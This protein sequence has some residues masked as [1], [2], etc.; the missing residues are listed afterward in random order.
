M[1]ITS[2]FSEAANREY[3]LVHHNGVFVGTIFQCLTNMK[4]HWSTRRDPLE[5]G[6]DYD[7]Y[8]HDT[9]ESAHKWLIY[10]VERRKEAMAP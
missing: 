2:T 8:C 3:F 4:W 5:R 9:I 1:N 6:A 7:G 10:G